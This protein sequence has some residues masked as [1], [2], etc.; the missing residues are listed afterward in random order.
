MGGLC[1]CVMLDAGREQSADQC[2]LRLPEQR[3]GPGGCPVSDIRPII[4][5][6]CAANTM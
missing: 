1:V 4:D 6:L 5:H 3:Q 2:H